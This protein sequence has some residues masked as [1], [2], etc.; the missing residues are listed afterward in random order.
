MIDPDAP[1]VAPASLTGLRANTLAAVVMLLLEYGL[2][3]SASLY[4]TLPTADQGKG[5]LPAF[6]AAVAHGPVVVTLHALLGTL[7]LG[8]AL[9]VVIRSLRARRPP[10]A[11]LAGVA[12]ASIAVEWWVT[13]RA[14]NSRGD[15]IPS[16][17]PASIRRCRS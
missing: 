7:L 12:L 10:L 9:G 11:V 15:L 16:R 3:V 5:L 1:V 17:R 6:G 8:A 14:V 2:G 4:A 13:R